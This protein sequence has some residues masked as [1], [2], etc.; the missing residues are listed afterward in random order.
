MEL[1]SPNPEASTNAKVLGMVQ[2]VPNT[3]FSAL[4]ILM[5]MASIPSFH[6]SLLTY[7]QLTYLIEL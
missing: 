2:S 1:A 5:F 7:L 6:N 4:L 3:L